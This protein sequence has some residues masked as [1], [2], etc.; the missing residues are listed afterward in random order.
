[1]AART[2]PPVIRAAKHRAALRWPYKLLYAP[3]RNGVHYHLYNVAEDPLEERDIAQTQRDTF[4]SLKA[5]LKREVFRHTNLMSV[6]DVIVTRPL[7]MEE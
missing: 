1:M 5:E 6:R 7:P 2:L 4:E 3:D